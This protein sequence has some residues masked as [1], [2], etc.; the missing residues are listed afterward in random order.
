MYRIEF[1]KRTKTFKL[2]LPYEISHIS[3][4]CIFQSEHY[5]EAM[6]EFRLQ[7]EKEIS[8]H[9]HIDYSLLKT[10]IELYAYDEITKERRLL[11]TIS[12]QNF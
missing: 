9:S 11:K 3:N 8:Y 1:T 6:D 7:C 4:A 2:D 12:I 10:M 5:S